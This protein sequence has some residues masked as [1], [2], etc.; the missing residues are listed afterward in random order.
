GLTSGSTIGEAVNF[1]RDLSNMPAGQLTPNRL[2]TFAQEVAKKS[3]GTITCRL[4]RGAQLRRLGA[5]ALLAVAQ[6]S[7]QPPV[8]IDLTYTPK[9]GASTDVLGFVGKSITFDSGGLDLKTADGMRTMKRDMAGGASV[10][11]AVSAIAALE[12]PISV[13]VVMAA[14]ENMPDGNSYK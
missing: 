6:G 2:A 1:A 7:T 11:A 14:T 5:H 12:L 8:L 10:L 9:S 3:G 13:R 4:F